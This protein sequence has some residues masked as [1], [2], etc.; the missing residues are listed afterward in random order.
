M[1]PERFHPGNHFKGVS[2]A[3]ADPTSM[4]PERF[5][6]GN[7]KAMNSA[8]HATIDFNEAGAFP[9]RKLFSSIWG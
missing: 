9:P 3:Q 5:H 4:R 8:P 7:A 2:Y 1:R 6:P